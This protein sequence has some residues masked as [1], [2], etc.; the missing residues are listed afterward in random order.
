MSFQ[1]LAEKRYSARKFSGV[2]VENE[3]LDLIL[4]AAQTAPTAANRQP[5]RILVIT[6]KDGLEKVDLC[7]S[8]R[9]GAPLVFFICYESAACWVRPFDGENSGQVDASIV[10]THM[11]LQA[12][13]IGL[14]TLWVMHFDPAKTVEQ[15][16]LGQGIVPVAMLVTGYRTE[17][18]VPSPKHTQRKPLEKL[19]L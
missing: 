10:T 9:Y 5:Q 18:S 13:D 14:G 2:P 6:E 3:K 4:K 17:D 15:F 11:M 16:G 8:C 1:E 12:E 7:T 19:M